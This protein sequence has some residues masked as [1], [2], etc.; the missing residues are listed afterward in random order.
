MKKLLHISLFV[1]SITIFEAFKPILLTRNGRKF[2]MNSETEKTD[3]THL[4]FKALFLKLFF[5][6]VFWKE[7]WRKKTDLKSVWRKKTE[8]KWSVEEK[9]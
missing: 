5:K 7:I 6:G 3:S 2:Q 8:L 4:R 1:I 9:N